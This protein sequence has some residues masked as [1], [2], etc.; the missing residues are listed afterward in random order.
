[1]A[2]KLLEEKVL[3]PIRGLLSQGVTPKKMSQAVAVGFVLG[4]TPMLGVST[5]LAVVVAAVFKLNQVAIQVANW[6]AYPAQIIM[7]IPF[8]RVG[9]WVFGLEPAAINPSDIATMFSDDFQA[10]VQH[11]GQ[12]LL[13]G[14]FSWLIAAVPLAMVIRWPAEKLLLNYFAQSEV[15]DEEP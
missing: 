9:E 14:W 3:K 2:L 11:Y 12:S 13:A 4:M 8:I 10:S 6:A 7:F 5:P 1:M 15:R